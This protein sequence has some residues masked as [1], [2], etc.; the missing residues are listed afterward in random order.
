MIRILGTMEQRL[1]EQYRTWI[2]NA[3]YNYFIT[4]GV[5][6]D[7]VMRPDEVLSKG[8]LL[9]FRMNKFYLG[10]Y[11]T[12]LSLKERFHFIG[13]QEGSG[14]LS[15]HHW[16]LHTV[17]PHKNADTSIEDFLLK[18]WKGR[19]PITDIQ[20]VY[21]DNGK[22]YVTKDLRPNRMNYYFFG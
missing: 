6:P 17:K 11:F 9:E 2:E 3:E 20:E 10:N 5:Q 7:K 21:S 4:L 16:L 15:H 8:R 18:N 12:K 13:F 14:L 22:R 19:Q 1:I